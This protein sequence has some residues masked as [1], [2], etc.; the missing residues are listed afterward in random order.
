MRELG[1]PC[2]K[3]AECFLRSAGEDGMFANV[4]TVRSE[5]DGRGLVFGVRRGSGSLWSSTAG[6]DADPMSSTGEA[7]VS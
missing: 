4:S 7:L 5:R 6:S 3:K 1:L 2:S